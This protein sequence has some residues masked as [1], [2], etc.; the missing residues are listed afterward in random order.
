[1]AAP[2]AT[3]A[4]TRLFSRWLPGSRCQVCA[5][6]Q[7]DAICALC[8][9]RHAPATRRCDRCAR[10]WPG[11]STDATAQA[12]WHCGACVL[13]PPPWQ[14]ARAAVDYGYPW[15]L[16]LARFKFRDQP[17]LADPL[18]ALLLASLQQ[19]ER[20]PV[21]CVL[22]APLA[23]E[24]LRE[25]GYNQ[26]WELARRVARPLGLPAQADWL[27]RPVGGAHQAALGRAARWRQVRDVF[28]LSPAGRA[29]VAGR[30]V[31]LVDDVMT[32]GATLQAL[33][34]LLGREGAASVQVWVVARTPEG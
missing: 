33:T 24:R 17:D 13:T 15:D 6:W 30:H 29:G 7:R 8:L 10:P 2:L 23:T 9:V 14:A 25:R 21:D 28:A 20:P 16:L 4:P 27:L 5:S 32:T 19:A 26:A 1:M 11:A 34:E 31:A 18:A 12:V 3:L 22:P